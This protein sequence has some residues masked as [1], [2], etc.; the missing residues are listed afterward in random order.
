MI[1]RKIRVTGLIAVAALSLTACV[2]VD[3]PERAFFWPDARLARENITLPANPPPEGAE[4]LV[5]RYAEGPIG[6]TRVRSA[7]AARPLILFC[8]GNMFRRE[9]SGGSRADI[10]AP[11]GDA[12][13]FDYPGY[14]DTAG[15]D[16]F[17]NFRAVGEVVADE[18]RRQADAEGRRLIVWGH[19]L[20][21]IVCSEMA[22][23]TR[24]DILVLET[25]TPGARA[26]VEQ[27]VGLMRP[28]VRVTLAPALET[29][30]IPAALNGYAGKVVVLEAGKDDTLPP[31]LSRR[32]ARALEAQGNRVDRIVFPAAGHNDVGR[33]PEFA[34]RLTAALAP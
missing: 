10:L 21:G 26:T 6:A 2:K 14:G 15:L 4:T 20:G 27:Q 31:A 9:A 8:G 1:L 22:A 16:T 3:V 23:R 17:A 7:D 34:A 24:A 25:T 13:M 33:Q 5:L 18:A 19:S 32:L 12:L 29:V 11:F 28:F 30:D